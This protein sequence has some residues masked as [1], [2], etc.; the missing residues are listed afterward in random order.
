MHRCLVIFKC[1]IIALFNPI[2]GKLFDKLGPRYITLVGMLLMFIGNTAFVLFDGNTSMTIVA[3]MYIIR[4]IGNT[5][6]LSPLLAYGVS[7]FAKK[8]MSHGNAIVNSARQ[9][10]GSLGSS[11]L[12]IIITTVSLNG[13]VDVYGINVSFGVQSILILIGFIISIIFI[14]PGKEKDGDLMMKDTIS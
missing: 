2:A 12:V 4:M 6:V 8:D 14:R 5:M 3:L 13:S 11:I 10:I 9:M 7:K 1:L